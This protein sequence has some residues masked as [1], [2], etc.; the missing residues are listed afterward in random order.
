MDQKNRRNDINQKNIVLF[1]GI[2]F[3]KNN[4]DQ[5]S[6]VKK[7][8]LN[9]FGLSDLPKDKQDELLIKITEA[10]LKRIFLETMEKLSEQGQ[11]EYENMIANGAAPRQMEEFLKANIS[12]YETL[13]QKVIEEFKNEMKQ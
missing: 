10:V 12:N 13:V 11:Q 3:K 5:D 8:I 7:I 9:E 6:Q 4:M 2:N 1:S